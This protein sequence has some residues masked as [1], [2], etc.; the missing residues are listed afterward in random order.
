MSLCV[1]S[2]LHVLSLLTHTM[3]NKH[4]YSRTCERNNINIS[5]TLILNCIHVY[6]YSSNRNESIHVL[7]C[8]YFRKMAYYKSISALLLAVFIGLFL[9]RPKGPQPTSVLNTT[10]DYIIGKLCIEIYI[11]QSI[12]LCNILM[13]SKNLNWNVCK[14]FTAYILTEGS[15]LHDLITC[16]IINPSVGDQVN[17]CC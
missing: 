6:E 16:G 2:V 13:P 3:Q 9:T 4:I 11:Y 15:G 12:S 7:F 17:I 1:C 8:C 14:H 10:Y 5:Q